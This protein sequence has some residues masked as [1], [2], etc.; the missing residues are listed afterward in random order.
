MNCSSTYRNQTSGEVDG[1]MEEDEGLQCAT[2]QNPCSRMPAAM[3]RW[4]VGLLWKL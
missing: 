3:L 4:C 2:S 1:F